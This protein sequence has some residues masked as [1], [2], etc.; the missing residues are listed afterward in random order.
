MRIDKFLSNLK[1]TSRSQAKKFLSMHA[2][3]NG[4]VLIQNVKTNVDLEQGIYIDDQKVF[5][6]ENIYLMINKPEGYLSATKDQ[7]FPCVVDLLKEPYNRFDF[8]IV[9]RLDIDTTGLLLL[10]TDGMFVHDVTHPSKHM[11]KTYIAVLDQ[12]EVDCS[13]LLEG[14]YIKDDKNQ[15]Y[16]AKALACHVEGD[17]AKIIID[18]GKFHQV[19]RMFEAIGCNVLQLKRISIGRLQLGN[20]EESSYKEI[21]KEDLYD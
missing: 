5:Y 20:L 3:R 7:R 10:T 15:T 2:V 8:M 4:D 14:V 16:F 17:T 1:Y 13:K 21:R 19:K 11:P 6:K 9:G 18:E 12:N